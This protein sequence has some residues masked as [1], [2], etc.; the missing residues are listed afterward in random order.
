MLDGLLFSV[1]ISWARQTNRLAPRACG[2]GA[3]DSIEPDSPVRRKT[4]RKVILLRFWLVIYKIVSKCFNYAHTINNSALMLVK[5]VS[6]V[7][8]NLIL[9]RC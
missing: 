7:T 6:H 2:S 3:L 1:Y 8:C 4:D 5:Y 9:C